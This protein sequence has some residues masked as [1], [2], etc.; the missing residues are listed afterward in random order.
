MVAR[1][2]K[3]HRKRPT[4]DVVKAAPSAGRAPPGRVAAR[5]RRPGP[6]AKEGEPR[7]VGGARNEHGTR[8]ARRVTCARC[9]TADHVPYVPRDQSKALCRACAAEVLR[10]YEAGTTVRAEMRSIKCTLCGTPFDLPVTVD[11]EDRDPLCKNC[12]RGFAVW[13]GSVD[14]PFEQRGQTVV[15]ERLSG[16]L[17]RKRKR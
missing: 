3:D 2:K 12:L 5:A 8:V 7:F 16:A 15:E 4:P 14:V 10:T 11:L 17:I 9:G 1:P 6:D 13:Q